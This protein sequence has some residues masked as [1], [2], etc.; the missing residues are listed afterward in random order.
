MPINILFGYKKIY[1]FH[2]LKNE[3]HMDYPLPPYTH[4]EE[5]KMNVAANLTWDLRKSPRFV[6]CML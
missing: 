4:G 3:Y 1:L 6:P 2:C 5:L